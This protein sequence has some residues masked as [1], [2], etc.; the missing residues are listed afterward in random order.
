MSDS[1]G[2]VRPIPVPAPNAYVP[3]KNARTTKKARGKIMED[4][5]GLVILMS[6]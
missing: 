1:R 4:P 2:I 3:G 6:V 5:I